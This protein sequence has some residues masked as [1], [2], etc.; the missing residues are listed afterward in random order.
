MATGAQIKNI[1][2]IF[3]YTFAGKAQVTIVDENTGERITFK[4]SRAK[5][6]VTKESKDVWFIW[7]QDGNTK[8]FAGTIFGKPGIDATYSW[9]KKNH[10]ERDSLIMGYM[11][12]FINRLGIDIRNN[13]R[14]LIAIN[15]MP[16]HIQI[17]HEGKCGHCGKTLTVPL[18]IENGIGPVCQNRIENDPNIVIKSYQRINN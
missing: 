6:R 5:D 18:S 12:A 2:D 16:E 4:F 15:E 17:W 10:H 1:N 11:K 9:G 14:K 7:A 3:N 8:R 13:G